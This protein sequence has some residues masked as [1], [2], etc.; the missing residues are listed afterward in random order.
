MIDDHT[1]SDPLPR[2]S[3]LRAGR[4]FLVIALDTLD[5]QTHTGIASFPR[6]API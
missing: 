1:S 6:I 4:L 2:V 5:T 3:A